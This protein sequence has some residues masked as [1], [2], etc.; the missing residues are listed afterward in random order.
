PT[1][2]VQFVGVLVFPYA[3]CTP[4]TPASVAQV[5]PKLTESKLVA[6]SSKL[7]VKL[8]PVDG[9]VS[10]SILSLVSILMLPKLLRNLIYTDFV[11]RTALD[12]RA[13]LA[14]HVVQLVGLLVF[15]YAT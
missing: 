11:P 12:V 10:R 4:H 14:L 9:V 7:I 5:V 13:I 1:H 3:T 6:G 2:D 8:P 15:P